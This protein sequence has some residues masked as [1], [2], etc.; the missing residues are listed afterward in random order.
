MRNGLE[1][2]W[3]GSEFTTMRTDGE[4]LSGHPVTVYGTTVGEEGVEVWTATFTRPSNNESEVEV[5]G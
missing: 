2:P 1:R 4:L 3:P 5:D